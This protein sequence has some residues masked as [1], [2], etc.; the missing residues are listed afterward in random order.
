MIGEMIND[1]VVAFH[2]LVWF[3]KEYVIKNTT[4]QVIA[5]FSSL[6][7]VGNMWANDDEEDDGS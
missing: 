7:Y 4:F 2:F 6:V 5:L 3:I 1:V